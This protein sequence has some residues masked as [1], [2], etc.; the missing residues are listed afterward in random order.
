MQS[1]NTQS[2]SSEKD[3]DSMRDHFN[4]ANHILRQ[5]TS[6]GSPPDRRNNF[7]TTL[8]NDIE[9]LIQETDIVLIRG[10]FLNLLV[11]DVYDDMYMVSQL[12]KSLDLAPMI[13]SCL[14]T[15]G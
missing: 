14:L 11:V 7:W 15:R 6:F 1:T 5:G 4:L 12:M 2:D 9:F 3:T 8:K 10:K 13:G